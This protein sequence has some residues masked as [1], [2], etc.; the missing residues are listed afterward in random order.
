LS[1]LADYRKIHKTAMF[2]THGETPQL[3]KWVAK[4]KGQIQFARKGKTSPMTL[5]PYKALESL[6]FEWD[7]GSARKTVWVNLPMT[8]AIATAQHK[9]HNYSENVSWGGGSQPKGPITGCS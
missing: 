1:E 5:S 8:I 3:A 9:S 7:R 4:P 2:L 6:G